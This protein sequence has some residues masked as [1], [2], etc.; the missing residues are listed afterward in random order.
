M[1][2]TIVTNASAEEIAGLVLAL[3]GQRDQ[4]IKLSID[5]GEVAKNIIATIRD[6]PPEE[7]TET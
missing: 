5:G 6:T 4:E 3:Q 1:Q 7:K 2:A